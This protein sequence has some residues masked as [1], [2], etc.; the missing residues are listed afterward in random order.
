MLAVVRKAVGMVDAWCVAVSN[1]G[2]V[3]RQAD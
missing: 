2:L 1:T 3:V